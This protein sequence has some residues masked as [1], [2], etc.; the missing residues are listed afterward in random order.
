M[1]RSNCLLILVTTIKQ[2]LAQPANQPETVKH[3][4]PQ[5]KNLSIKRSLRCRHC[6]HNVIKPEYN[7]S[8]IKYRIQL[9]ASYHVPEVRFVKA[10]QLVAGGKGFVT[11]R[12]V[13]PTIHDMTLTIMELP[14]EEEEKEMIDE[15]RKT[16]D[17]SFGNE[18]MS[19][20][21]NF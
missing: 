2:R 1:E 21:Y 11:L 3:L 5:H 13:N 6:E 15:L 7:P 19:K 9:F 8:S 4:Y 17:V 14:T 18:K 12:F 20:D 16:F 10:D